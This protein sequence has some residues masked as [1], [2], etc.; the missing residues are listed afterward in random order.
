MT[1]G[2][3]SVGNDRPRRS[4]QP[5][6]SPDNLGNVAMDNEKLEWGKREQWR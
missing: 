5:K 1:E 4:G 6:A 3:T 2:G